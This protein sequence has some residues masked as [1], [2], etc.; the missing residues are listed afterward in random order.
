MQILCCLTKARAQWKSH[1]CLPVRRSAHHDCMKQGKL[2]I[3][4]DEFLESRSSMKVCAVTFQSLLPYHTHSDG[5]TRE[6][7]LPLTSSL[8]ES[9]YQVDVLS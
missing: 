6:K 7:A 2:K 4:L 9:N 8:D 3:V 1:E 5:H